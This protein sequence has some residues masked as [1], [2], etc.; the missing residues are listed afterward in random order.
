VVGTSHS[1]HG[2]FEAFRWTNGTGMIGL[3]DL[4]GGD[5]LS[6][7]TSVSPDGSAVVGRG[8]SQEFAL[9]DAFRWTFQTGIQPLGHFSTPDYNFSYALGVSGDGLIAVGGSRSV[10]GNEA[11]RW[12]ENEG[13]VGL[14][15]LPGG[16]FESY[17]DAISADGKVIVGE[18]K[19]T[20]ALEAFRWTAEEGMQ[21]L[22]FIPGLT[23]ESHANS[24]SDDGSVIVGSDGLQAW[25]WTK[26]TG[27]T[28]LNV[29]L[30]F[31]GIDQRPISVSGDGSTIVGSE[32]IDGGPRAFRWDATHGTRN[33]QSLL[34]TDY[35]LI[36]DGWTLTYANSVSFD[37]TVIVGEG[38]NP[39]GRPEA[40]VVSLATPEPTSSVMFLIGILALPVRRRAMVS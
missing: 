33:L 36:L 32:S 5:F 7:A 40:W 8:T 20:A 17:A 18:S 37:G 21:G 16:A 12:T 34:Q 28:P 35:G 22:G 4:V 1:S 19:S 13:L 24:V 26:Q 29:E 38:I 27:I 31:N 3:G 15:D 10:A 14:G 9:D 25:R 39:K 30:E 23:V 11:F 2:G 6:M